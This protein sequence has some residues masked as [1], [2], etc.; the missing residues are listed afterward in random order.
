MFAKAIA[1]TTRRLVGE[2]HPRTVT[3]VAVGA[4]RGD[5]AI[6]LHVPIQLL[7]HR[8]GHCIDSRLTCLTMQRNF[9]FSRH[10]MALKNFRLAFSFP[11]TTR[12][13]RERVAVV[14]VMLHQ[15]TQHTLSAR[16]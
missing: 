4:A 1:P 13:G 7:D 6:W 9:G 5:E 11:D 3:V 8:I 14:G 10:S 15:T 12:E 16:L 2:M